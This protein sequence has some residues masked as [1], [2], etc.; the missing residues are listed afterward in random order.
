MPIFSFFPGV[1]DAYLRRRTRR[2]KVLK[3][4][5]EANHAIIANDTKEDKEEWSERRA[6]TE[7]VLSAAKSWHT[8]PSDDNATE[9]MDAAVHM[10]R[11]YPEDSHAGQII[12]HVAEAIAESDHAAASRMRQA[13]NP[14][15]TPD[16]TRQAAALAEAWENRV[17]QKKP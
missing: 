4:A 3:R 15:A 2:R 16:V 9:L 8:R 11:E 17:R 5:I 7:K 1:E 13:W 14:T 12:C 10:L 6:N